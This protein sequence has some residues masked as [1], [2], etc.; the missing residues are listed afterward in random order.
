MQANP[1]PE[2]AELFTQLVQPG[3]HRPA[4][5]ETAAVF[6]ID[7]IGAGVLRDHQQFLD[8][9]G[10]EKLGLAQHFAERPRDQIAAQAGDDA[11]TAT[12]VAAFGNLQ[13]GVMIGRQPNTLRR[14]QID[15]GIM[16]G[17]W[18]QMRMHGLHHFLRRVR[19]GHR[20]HLRMHAL[21]DVVAGG[22]LL[23]A[24][25]A[26][27]DHPAVFS[28]CFADR[29][30]RFLDRRIDKA[31]GVDHHQIGAIVLPRDGIAFAAQAGQDQFGIGRR[32]GAAERNEADGRRVADVLRHYGLFLPFRGARRLGDLGRAGCGFIGKNLACLFFQALLHLLKDFLGLIDIGSHHPLHCRPL[33]TEELGP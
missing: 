4:F 24:E 20:Q 29:V 14:H 32:L 33:E 18:R 9:G 19:P 26:G 30:E 28:E 17:R 13:V 15:E 6:D 3:L 16:P 12:M 7:A 25:A 5:D 10:G 2:F 21:H 31:A 27:N 22:I 23:R 1:Q 11:E 8:P